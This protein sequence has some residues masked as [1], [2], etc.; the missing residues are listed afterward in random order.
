MKKA[1]ELLHGLA[2]MMRLAALDA[3]EKKPQTMISDGSQNL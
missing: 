1:E 3:L 2:L